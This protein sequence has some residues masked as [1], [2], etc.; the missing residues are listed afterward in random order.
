MYCT[1]LCL[2]LLPLVSS[3]LNGK[4]HCNRLLMCFHIHLIYSYA[5]FFCTLFSILSVLVYFCEL[6]LLLYTALS[7]PILYKFTDH[8]QLVETQFQSINIISYH[9][10]S[11][12]IISYHIA[13]SC[14]Q[15]IALHFFR[16]T[17]FDHIL[18]S[19]CSKH[20]KFRTPIDKQF[21][22]KESLTTR[23][24]SLS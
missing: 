21:K 6:F 5:I 14:S 7:F 22:Q 11:Y 18:C 15:Y 10:I 1:A 3:L 19:M 12:H 23:F 16:T 24:V 13:T 4:S 8:S 20:N 9:I 2:S 17:P